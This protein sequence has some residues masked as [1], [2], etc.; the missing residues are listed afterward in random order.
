MIPMTAYVAPVRLT[1]GSHVRINGRP[2]LVERSTETSRVFVCRESGDEVA[3]SMSAQIQMMREQRLTSEVSYQSLDRNTLLALETDWGA[4]SEIER[5]SANRKFPFVK[6]IDELPTHQRHRTKFVQPVLAAAHAEA[7]LPFDEVPSV[8]RARKW[9]R[10]WLV[11]GRD[12]RAIV[13]WHSKKGNRVPR[14][15]HWIYDEVEAAI[16]EVFATDPPGTEAAAQERARDRV[17]L[18]AKRDS[19]AIPP[20]AKRVIGQHLARRLIERRDQYELASVRFGKREADRMYAM[21]GAG[22]QA[23]RHLAEVEVDHTLLDVQIVDESG[24]RLGKP[25]L[26]ILFDRYT[27]MIIGFSLS[28]VP[29]SWVSVMDALQNAVLPKDSDIDDICQG[30]ERPASDWPAFGVPDTLYADRGAE[31]RSLSMRGTESVLNMKI[32]DL[33]PASGEKKGKV[34]RF[35]GSS[36]TRLVHLLPGT[37]FSNVVERRKSKHDSERQA[38]LTLGDLRYVVLTWIVDIYNQTTHSRT[39]MTPAARWQKSVDQWG[40]KPPPPAETIRPLTG[41]TPHRTLNKDGVRYKRLRWNSNGFQALRARNGGGDVIIRIDP[42]DLSTAWVLD[43]ENREWIAGDLVSEERATDQTLAQ[44][45]HSKRQ[46][47]DATPFDADAAMRRAEA[48]QRILDV[49]ASKRKPS[50]KRKTAFVKDGRKPAEHLRPDRVDPEASAGG[51]GSHDIDRPPDRPPQ[52]AR[53]PW[54]EQVLPDR[55]SSS[56]STARSATKPPSAKT[57]PDPPA[58]PSSRPAG[59]YSTKRRK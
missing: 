56:G 55:P 59:S 39:G 19:L 42:S 13:D 58:A 51:L 15:P 7:A 4:F 8:R 41:L 33:P 22:P 12:I 21:V 10:K 27:R 11:A 35:F 46:A 3:I 25:W 50:P 16:D 48:G 53:G 34:E 31:F 30:R 45:Q 23:A 49:V 36:A 54:R 5:L 37:T 57:P 6:A 9:Y 14:L 32:V 43:E 17:M 1:A 18:R 38:C 40:L 29:P 26:T 24:L 44:W 2:Y 47:Q 20:G 52:D 28:F